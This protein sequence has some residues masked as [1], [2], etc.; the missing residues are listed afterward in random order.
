[1]DERKCYEPA[2]RRRRAMQADAH[3]DRCLEKVT[4]SNQDSKEM[5]TRHAWGDISTCPGFATAH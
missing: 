4:P 2:L 3:V 1:M 5:S